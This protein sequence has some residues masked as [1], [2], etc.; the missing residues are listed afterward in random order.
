MVLVMF[1]IE[2]L[3]SHNQAQNP[4]YLFIRQAVIH[5]QADDLFGH[6]GGHGQVVGMCGPEAA[7]GAERADQRVEVAA[8]QHVVLFHLEIEFVAAHAIFLF[9]HEDGEVG[10]VVAHAG[11]VVHEADAP[12]AAQPLAIGLG[13]V[14]PALDGPVHLAEVHQP[15]GGA[16]LVHLAVDAGGDDRRLARETEVFQVVDAALGLLVV[17]HEGAALDG[18]VD[19]GGVETERRQV[20]GFQDAL[21]VH[22]HTESMGGVVDDF[23]PIG[24]GYF[25]D[26]RR[27]TRPPVHV[28]RHDGRRAGRDG[29]LYPFRVEV[30]RLGV[31]VHEHGLDAVPPQ[32]VGR[33]HEAERRGDHLARDAQG[34]QGRD[35]RQGAVGEQADERHA[36]VLAQGAFQFLVV[37]PVVGDP[38]A[39]PNVFQID[40]QFIQRGQQ[41]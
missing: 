18:V 40:V 9:I 16:H 14:A 32:G 41:R 31:D 28:H 3:M 11:E 33:G 23:Q 13:H 7:V 39:L 38:P 4:F 2:F 10:V 34:L 19:L 22:P 12:H 17:H 24:V 1:P 36:E 29:G 21:A 37:V 30:A 15:V 27:V 25:L 35:E 26:A 5:R 20:A 8:A 6:A